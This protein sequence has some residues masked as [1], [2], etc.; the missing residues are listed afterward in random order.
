MSQDYQYT[1]IPYTQLSTEAL[2]GVIESFINREGTD[3]G[4]EEYTFEQK[5]L[6][7]RAQIERGDAV[8]VFD[9][10]TQSVGILHKDQLS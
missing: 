3:Y 9:H 4:Q 1:P 10:D 8:I 7:V 2:D 5:Y 6:Q